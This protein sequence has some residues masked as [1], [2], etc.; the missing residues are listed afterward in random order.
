[1]LTL[2]V[3]KRDTNESVDALRASGVTPCVFYGPKEA[4][5]AIS[6][7]TQTLESVWKEAGETTLV[8]LEG[9]DSPK[10][11]LIHDVQVH[12]VTGRIT[13]ADFYVL[14]KGKK[15][16]VTVPLR[17]VGECPAEKAGFILAKSLYEIDIEVSPS[18][19]PHHLD[20]SLSN[21]NAVGD[22]LTAAD[23]VLPKSAILKTDADEVL[24]SV[25]EFEEVNEAA[26]LP[27]K[28]SLAAPVA[29]ETKEEK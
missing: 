22:L 5:N 27:T 9:L 4:P 20:V 6:V 10:E 29:E 24:V 23:V 11:T 21:L 3:S 26:Q 1:M 28:E 8:V 13:H 2:T 15:V 16:E 17:F 12:P 25:T 19:L 14:E 18:E 7:P